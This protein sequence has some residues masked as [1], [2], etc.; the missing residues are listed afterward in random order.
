M[1]KKI[2]NSVL[3]AHSAKEI[4]TELNERFG[5][6]NGTSLFQVQ[7]E[8][9]S[10]AQGSTNITCYYAKAKRLWDELGSLL[11]LPACSCNVVDTIIKFQH[12]QK[13]NLIFNES[14]TTIR[15]GTLTMK[16]L[17]SVA[18][19]YSFLIREE[20]QRELHNVPYFNGGSI[21]LD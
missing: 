20:K 18:Q 14:Y 21:H 16:P 4:W 3:Y 10:L 15:G 11:V 2:S 1:G 19:A 17:P 9:W 6:S 5:Q 13:L 7:K 8:F 12:D